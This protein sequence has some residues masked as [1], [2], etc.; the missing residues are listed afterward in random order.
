[1]YG[2]NPSEKDLKII[3]SAPAFKSEKGE[4]PKV[5]HYCWFGGNPLPESALKCI[6][7]WKKYF[8]DFKI[9]EWNETNFN[10][11]EIAY[12]K[13]A[14]ERKKYAFL[15]DFARFAVLYLY[16]GLY[17]DTDV[18]V[19]KSFEPILK[20]G[21]FMGCEKETAFSVAAGL[22]LGVNAKSEIYKELTESYL[23][24][25]FIK[26]DGSNNIKTIVERTTEI[27]CKYGLKNTSEIQTVEG[28][29]IYP[30]EYF[31]PK[32]MDSDEMVITENT[33]SIHHYDAT[34]ADELDK[35]SGRRAFKLKKIF[36]SR[37]GGMINVVIYGYQKY[38]IIGSIKKFLR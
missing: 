14:Y 4:I 28:I 9:I 30:K 13:E 36:G 3:N 18:E 29:M 15:S 16:G 33:Y 19:I 20:N 24:D 2:V 7:S 25:R 17:F 5:I 34:W 21:P 27:L 26:E 8:P 22:G 35:K 37:L 23:N 1:M 10:V 6:E 32:I 12:T 11:N 31:C 38:G